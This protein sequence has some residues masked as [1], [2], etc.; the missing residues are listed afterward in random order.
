MNNSGRLTTMQFTA[1][2]PWVL[3]FISA[4]NYN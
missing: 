1:G 2:K 4:I 3:E